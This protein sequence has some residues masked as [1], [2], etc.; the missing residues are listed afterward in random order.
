MPAT[1]LIPFRSGL[2]F[3]DDLLILAGHYGLNPL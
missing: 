1:V 3:Y 2:L